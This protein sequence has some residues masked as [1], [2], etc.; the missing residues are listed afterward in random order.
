MSKIPPHIQKLANSRD[1]QPSVRIGKSGITENLITEID[2][3]LSRKEVVKVKIN[4]GLFDK[5]DIKQVWEHLSSETN[6]NIVSS[7]GNVCV[8]WR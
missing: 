5:G 8:L 4:R 3:Q 1:F 6:S 7:R 2:E